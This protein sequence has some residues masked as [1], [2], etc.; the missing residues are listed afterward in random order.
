ML[1][2]VSISSATNS[3]LSRGVHNFQH[4]TH[5]PSGSLMKEKCNQHLCTLQYPFSVSKINRLTPSNFKLT[6]TNPMAHKFLISKWLETLLNT[7]VSLWR[8]YI[9]SG[10]N[11]V[12]RG[13]IS[14]KTHPN[15]RSLLQYPVNF[16][17]GIPH[18]GPISHH[19]LV[20]MDIRCIPKKK[21]KQFFQDVRRMPFSQNDDPICPGFQL[22]YL[23][24]CR[25]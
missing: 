7:S 22:V 19:V 6:V 10:K 9:T 5:P 17:S 2:H 13:M 16:Q 8:N 15:L 14:T 1:F 23:F 21:G 20:L 25:C 24:R 18:F 3:K 11:L 4:P 12:I